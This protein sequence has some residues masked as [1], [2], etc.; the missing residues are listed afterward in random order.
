M[1][2]K[3]SYEEELLITEINL[4]EVDKVREELPILKKID[5]MIFMS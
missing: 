4:K 2:K 3:A 5:E 1:L